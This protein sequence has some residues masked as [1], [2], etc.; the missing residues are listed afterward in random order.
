MTHRPPCLCSPECRIVTAMR[1]WT[2]SEPR[3]ERIE[4]HTTGRCLT[5]DEWRRQR[6]RI[7]IATATRQ[8]GH[9]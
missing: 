9:P 4:P 5:P 7:L 1:A 8:G 2:P 6:D 3:R